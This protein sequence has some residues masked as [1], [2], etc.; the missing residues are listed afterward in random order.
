MFTVVCN[1][2]EESCIT[3]LVNKQATQVISTFQ[4]SSIWACQYY[5]GVSIKIEVADAFRRSSV[6]IE[7]PDYYSCKVVVIFFLGWYAYRDQETAFKQLCQVSDH[8][9]NNALNCPCPD[10]KI[11]YCETGIF[12][13]PSASCKVTLKAPT[14]ALKFRQTL[15]WLLLHYL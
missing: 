7:T 9:V 3:I 2:D 12:S 15:L 6:L 5:S 1:S 13:S 10:A 4:Q 11:V 8:T 14:P